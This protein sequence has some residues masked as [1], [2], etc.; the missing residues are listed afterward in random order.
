MST[1]NAWTFL[2]THARVLLAIS[3]D[4]NAR[5]IDLARVVGVT[6][7]TAQKVVRDLETDGYITV[8]KEGR[9]NCYEIDVSKRFRHPV[10]RDHSIAHLLEVLGEVE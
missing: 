10:A 4:T 5:L 9:R 7:R 8:V 2:T 3:R 1:E 6:E